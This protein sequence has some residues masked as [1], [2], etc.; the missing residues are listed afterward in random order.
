MVDKSE[1]LDMRKESNPKD[2]DKDSNHK[3]SPV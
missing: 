2:I 3:D 1:S